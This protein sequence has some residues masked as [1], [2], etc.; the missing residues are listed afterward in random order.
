MWN[1]VTWTPN[2]LV[3]LLLFFLF[4]FR[5]A[6]LSLLHKY[7]THSNLN[8]VEVLQILPEKWW[9]KS[10]SQPEKN[11]N[12]QNSAVCF[13]FFVLLHCFRSLDSVSSY[14]THSIRHLITSEHESQMLIQLSSLA[15]LKS[16]SNFGYESGKSIILTRERSA[17]FFYI[18]YNY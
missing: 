16:R 5:I 2:I 17:H 14:L 6:I 12:S 8:V 11:Q 1:I 9:A 18:E 3:I 15:Y 10:L 4:D 7:A 13:F